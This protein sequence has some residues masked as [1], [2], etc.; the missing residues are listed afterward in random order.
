MVRSAADTTGVTRN[1]VAATMMADFMCSPRVINGIGFPFET[2]VKG[3]LEPLPDD[4]GALIQVRE[5]RCLGG[6]CSSRS[7]MTFM[8]ARQA[9]GSDQSVI[10][11]SRPRLLSR[12]C[13]RRDASR[14]VGP[15]VRP[16]GDGLDRGRQGTAL[17]RQRVLDADGG[18]RNH[19]A[20]H[21]RVLLEL[22]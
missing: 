10:P 16:F 17:L 8:L 19:G 20:L 15:L 21:D 14:H 5:S 22:L 12:S 2:G 4:G 6:P 11:G 3:V 13:F 1:N 9:Q 7:A 18:L